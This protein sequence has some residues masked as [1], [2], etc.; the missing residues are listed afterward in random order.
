[1]VGHQILGLTPTPLFKFQFT[2]PSAVRTCTRHVHLPK[3]NYGKTGPDG[4]PTACQSP[5]SIFAHGAS[6]PQLV[7]QL[8]PLPFSHPSFGD[9]PSRTDR[10]V[11]PQL[12]I[13]LA[14]AAGVP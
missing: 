5:P 4:C 10:A 11:K 12:E 3:K 1:M 6:F 13:D 2:L 8:P 9:G 14:E 7:Q